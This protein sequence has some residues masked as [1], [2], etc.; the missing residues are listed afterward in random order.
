MGCVT[1]GNGNG[2]LWVLAG[3]SLGLSC[4]CAKVV[5]EVNRNRGLA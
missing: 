4:K 5:L 2:K 3:S 1:A